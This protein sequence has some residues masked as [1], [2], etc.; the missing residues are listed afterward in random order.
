MSI[1]NTQVHDKIRKVPL[2]C[3]LLSCRM[4]FVRTQNEFELAIMVNE[5]EVFELLRFDCSVTI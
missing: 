5:P 3:I 4:N 2:I 1:R